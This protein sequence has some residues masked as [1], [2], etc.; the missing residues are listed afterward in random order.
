MDT[1]FFENFYIS[2]K[3]DPSL[4][5]L[6]VERRGFC[7]GQDFEAFNLKIIEATTYYQCYKQISVNTA[8]KVIAQEDQKWFTEIYWGKVA[9]VGLKYLA[10][11]T[12][13]SKIAQLSI[14]SVKQR[15]PTVGIETHYFSTL[16]EAK[17]WIRTK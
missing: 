3:Y 5:C 4:S 8:M 2:I 12:P 6:M 13:S 1:N 10:V 7:T 9:E 14:D 17:E 15:K 16:D 11:I